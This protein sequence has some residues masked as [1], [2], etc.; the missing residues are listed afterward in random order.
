LAVVVVVVVEAVKVVE[1][2]DGISKKLLLGE[3]IGLLISFDFFDIIAL[4]IG[5]VSNV[6]CFS[7]LV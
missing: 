3:S 1:F 7:V 2:I 5:L 4:F 6:S